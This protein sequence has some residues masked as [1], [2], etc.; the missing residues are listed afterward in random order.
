MK[1]LFEG[2]VII[3]HENFNTQ[4]A[5]RA[6]GPLAGPIL[7][8]RYGFKNISVTTSTLYRVAISGG[9]DVAGPI[10]DRGDELFTRKLGF[11]YNGGGSGVFPG[12]R[13]NSITNT[14]VDV[15]FD[16]HRVVKLS[17]FYVLMEIEQQGVVSLRECLQFLELRYLDRPIIEILNVLKISKRSP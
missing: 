12:F 9:N 11:I 3:Q 6:F 1:D 8:T 16:V 2:D 10:F 7:L 15:F 4:F 17:N 5:R 14:Y 13:A